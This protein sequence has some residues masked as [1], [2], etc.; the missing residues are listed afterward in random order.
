MD[1]LAREVVTRVTDA[2]LQQSATNERTNVLLERLDA[3]LAVPP[4]QAAMSKAS[5][6]WLVVLVSLA[7]AA[8]SYA[9]ARHVD[10]YRAQ[11]LAGRTR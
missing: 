10:E 2:V 6:A 1:D 7:A 9:G 4:P 5:V 8:G 11:A 3:R